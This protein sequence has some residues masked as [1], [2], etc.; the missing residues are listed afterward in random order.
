MSQGFFGCALCIAGCA[1]G[2]TGNQGRRVDSGLARRIGGCREWRQ[3]IQ[4][5]GVDP[6]FSWP[7]ATR[8]P[9]C[10]CGGVPHWVSAARGASRWPRLEAERG[11]SKIQLSSLAAAAGIRF[12]SCIIKLQLQHDDHPDDP[13]A[14]TTDRD[15]PP[16]APQKPRL[17]T[18]AIM[19]EKRPAADQGQLVVK[20]QNVGS[21]RALTRQGASGS[22]ALIQTVR[23]PSPCR[24]ICVASSDP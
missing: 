8:V 4:F 22:G 16:I 9:W 23:T 13:C 2:W 18:P 12:W 17:D 24:N 21:S 14:Y 6:K 20:R 11:G 5:Q 10:R 3:A 7:A 1:R 19:S 15:H